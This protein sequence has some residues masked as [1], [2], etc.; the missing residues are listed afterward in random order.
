VDDVKRFADITEKA[1]ATGVPDVSTFVARR[2]MLGGF[3]SALTSG[4][5]LVSAG[6]A[7]GAVG[8]AAMS[9][10]SA[11]VGAMIMRYGA[12]VLAKPYTVKLME[13]AIDPATS[14]Q[15]AQNM[16]SRLIRSLPDDEGGE[17]VGPTR[18]QQPAAPAPIGIRQ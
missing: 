4:L 5:P 16:L 8:G 12:R 9:I 7:G 18:M 3:K 14:P 2:A 1:L 10:P 17:G 15:V 13:K 6:A 11:M